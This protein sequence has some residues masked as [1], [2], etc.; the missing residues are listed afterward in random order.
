MRIAEQLY[1]AP[2]VPFR[3]IDL[4]G[5]ALP[6]QFDA[7]IRGF[8]LDPALALANSGRAFASGLLLVVTIDAIAR[9]DSDKKRVGERIRDWC[10]RRIPS[11]SSARMRDRFTEDFRNGLVHEARVK[12]G[13]EFDLQIR[14]AAILEPSRLVVN[15]H[16]LANEVSAGLATFIA[17]LES[18]FAANQGFVH[19]VLSEF[20][21][22]LNH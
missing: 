2:N 9:L 19:R 11:F 8:Y 16:L 1:F 4:T 17:I 12:N 20:H 7:R 13:S 18:D 5:V 3:Q 22:E 10:K 21:Y 6:E 14:R 15:P